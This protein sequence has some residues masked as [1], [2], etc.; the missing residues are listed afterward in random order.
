MPQL[1]R[2]LTIKINVFV[3]IHGNV[4]V[5]IHIN[6]HVQ[7][8]GNVHVQIHKC[9]NIIVVISFIGFYEVTLT[10]EYYDTIVLVKQYLT[11]L[12]FKSLL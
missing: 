6:L 3:Q 12:L 4:H 9:T 10:K 1:K 2:Y 7:I 11:F 5:Q 8:H